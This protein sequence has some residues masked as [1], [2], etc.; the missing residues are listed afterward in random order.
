MDTK[1]YHTKFQSNIYF[2][3][4]DI[5]VQKNYMKNKMLAF[6]APYLGK[7]KYYLHIHYIIW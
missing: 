5:R 4:W 6:T 2:S 7:G 3:Y 1:S